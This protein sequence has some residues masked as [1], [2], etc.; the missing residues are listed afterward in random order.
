MRSAFKAA[1]RTRRKEE[2]SS[3]AT[4]RAR[5]AEIWQQAKDASTNHWYLTEKRVQ[6]FGTRVSANGDLIVPVHG[7]DQTLHGL[8]FIRKGKLKG[9]HLRSY[10]KGTRKAGSFFILG[11]PVVDRCGIAEGFATA[12]SICEALQQPVAC[13][14]DAGNIEQV[15]DE[16]R[17]LF[18][19]AELTIFADNDTATQQLTG[20]NPGL[21]A[22]TAA[23]KAIGARLATPIFEK[24]TK[25]ETDFNDLARV[26]GPDA[27]RE[28]HRRAQSF[29]QWPPPLPTRLGPD[30]YTDLANAELLVTDYG[31]RLCYTASRGWCDFKPP[32]VPDSN[33]VQA[34]ACALGQSIRSRAEQVESEDRL[35]EARSLR[36][37]SARQR[38]DMRAWAARSENSGRISAAV[39]L[40]R[41]YLVVPGGHLDTQTHLLGFPNGVLDLKARI[42]RA[43]QPADLVSLTLGCPYDPEAKAP[44]FRRF[45]RELFPKKLALRRFLQRAFG[46][47]L[48]GVQLEHLILV[49]FGQGRNGKGAL[50]R[51][52]LNVFGD[53]AVTAPANLLVATKAERHPSELAVL[54]GRRLVIHGETNRGAEFDAAKMK[55]LTGGDAVSARGMHKE[56][57]SFRPSHLLVMHTNQLLRVNDNSAGFWE[58][59]KVV[60]FNQVFSS[61]TDPSLESTLSSE[62][63]GIANWMLEGL[64]SY[65]RVGLPIPNAVLRASAE[66][67][68]AEDDVG[69]FLGEKTLKCAGKSLSIADMYDAYLQWC[70][71]R[72]VEVMTKLQLGEQLVKRGYTR[73]KSTGGRRVH[74]GLQLR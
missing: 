4:C 37:D 66:Y 15:A 34:F 71:G 20:R 24:Q 49:F 30:P 69:R 3:R 64:W 17:R 1:K 61:R 2:E 35:A 72:D 63:S 73:K 23:A 68:F 22:A 9:Q 60:P 41:N 40:A 48:K 55:N 65:E 33:A 11:G 18:P 46:Y 36:Q 52:I 59:V 6:P 56:W 13:A 58:R 5:A 16:L 21:E 42:F 47:S 70:K 74:V 44:R 12:A 43:H 10:L 53:Y 26:Q 29:A 57:F 62:A 31:G 32:W 25:S 19:H 7:S 67:R 38:Q 14:F 8:Q 45:V 51:A 28:A 39:R 54:A 50:I 27:V